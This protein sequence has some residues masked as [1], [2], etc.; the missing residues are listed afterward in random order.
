MREFLCEKLDINL[1]SLDR[2]K[3][4]ESNEW[5]RFKDISKWKDKCIRCSHTIDSGW[6]KEDFPSECF[7]F[8]CVNEII[9]TPTMVTLSEFH[10]LFDKMTPKHAR[11]LIA[12]LDMHVEDIVDNYPKLILLALSENL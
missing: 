1:I 3:D 7:C 8:D 9:P 10:E 4:S 11:N 2:G 6:L 5:V 12:R